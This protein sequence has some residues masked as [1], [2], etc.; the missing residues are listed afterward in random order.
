MVKITPVSH[1]H[2]LL[3][4]IL[5]FVHYTSSRNLPI[6]PFR[7]SG[8][9]RIPHVN[10]S[11][12]LTSNDDL[13]I[14]TNVGDLLHVLASHSLPTQI[15]QA[16]LL[17]LSVTA[18][19]GAPRPR[20]ANIK[21]FRS[22]RTVFIAGGINHETPLQQ[23]YFEI[24]NSFPDHWDRWGEAKFYELPPLIWLQDR[25]PLYWERIQSLMTIER[26]DKLIKEAGYRQEYDLV[27]LN[28]MERRPLQYCFQGLWPGP[29]V[30]NVVV[31]VVTGL[32]KEVGYPC[33]IDVR[34]RVIG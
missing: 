19:T 6:L 24:R 33:G 7:T 22:I 16:K 8:T 17:G 18:G 1:R 5:L 32:V 15:N 9:V 10:H 4:L 30:R 3:L 23:Q 12:N 27:M 14:N 11:S 34:G 20:S 25:R 21:D 31:E 13:T 26:A 29:D 2:P 28:E